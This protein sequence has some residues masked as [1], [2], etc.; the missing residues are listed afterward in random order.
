MKIYFHL[1][2]RLGNQLFQWAYLHE[3]VNQGH[4]IQIFTDKYHN[5]ISQE[6]DLNLLIA[7]CSHLNASTVRNEL[8]LILKIRERLISGGRISRLIAEV[9]PVFIETPITFQAK[10]FPI[11]MDG[12][13]IDK[14]WPLKYQDVICQ[15]FNNLRKE[16]EFHSYQIKT[17]SA[18]FSKTTIHIRR[19]DLRNFKST[20]GLLSREYYSPLF[21]KKQNNLVLSDSVDEAKEMC[22]NAKNCKFVDH[23]DDE[24]W[25]ALLLMSTSARVVMSNSTLSWWGGF[26]AAKLNQAQVYMPKPFYRDLSKFDEL[27][28]LTEFITHDSIFE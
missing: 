7:Q 3:L 11:L 25:K 6:P 10:R 17:L 9:F 4:E 22:V 26:F 8:G 19:G 5:D 27:L 20:F 24:V 12:F 2:G 23:R 18:D 21:S 15:E 28:P 14:E 13:F 16:I 1:S